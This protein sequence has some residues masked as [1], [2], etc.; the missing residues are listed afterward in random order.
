MSGVCRVLCVFIHSGVDTDCAARLVV[1]VGMIWVCGVDPGSA[2]TAWLILGDSG[3]VM[4]RL[5]DREPGDSLDV[6]CDYLCNRLAADLTEHGP[7]GVVGIEGCV[8]P[9]P[10]VRISNPQPIIDTAWVAGELRRAI[11]DIPTVGA[12]MIV[13]PG[14]HGKAGRIGYPAALWGKTEG[15]AGTGKLRHVRAAFDIAGWARANHRRH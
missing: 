12:V 5:L 4:S 1:A 13:P 15:D 10:H 9:N 8:A 11:I 6:W 2:H 14:G 7:V 3:P